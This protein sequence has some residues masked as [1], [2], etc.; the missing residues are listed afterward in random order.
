MTAFTV[1]RLATAI[2]IYEAAT[3]A[4]RGID[5]DSDEGNRWANIASEAAA[6][7]RGYETLPA[8]AKAGEIGSRPLAPRLR[9]VVGHPD[10]VDYLDV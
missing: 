10:P 2:R 7:S 4:L 6:L 5:R 1:S 9:L 3:L 8:H